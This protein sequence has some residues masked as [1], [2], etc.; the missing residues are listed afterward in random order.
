MNNFVFDNIIGWV[1]GAIVV[2]VFV[3]NNKKL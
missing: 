1:I 2:G 3:L